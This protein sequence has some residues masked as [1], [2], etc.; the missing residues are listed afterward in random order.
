MKYAIIGSGKIGTALARLFAQKNLAVGLTNS[1][2]PETLASL[3]K[4]LGSSVSA[5]SLQDATGAEVIFLAVPYAAHQDVAKLLPAWQDKIIVDATNAFGVGPERLGGR[6]SSEIV[7]RAFTG[8]R[9]VKAFN[10]LPAAQLGANPPASGQ[11][12]AIFVSSND[13]EAS[14]SVAALATQLGLAPVELGPLAQGG[15][16]L[17]VLDGKPGGLLLQNLALLD[18]AP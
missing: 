17:H 3:T 1:R 2:G 12:Q 7:A 10:H 4:E 13:A 15:T 11:R 6:L 14:A 18:E 5:Q 8:A 9:I 16:P